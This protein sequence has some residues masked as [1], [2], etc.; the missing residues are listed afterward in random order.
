MSCVCGLE[1]VCPYGSTTLDCPE[2]R[3]H[4]APKWYERLFGFLADL[5]MRH[6]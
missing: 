2:W 4:V 6:G 1:K 5:F 3:R